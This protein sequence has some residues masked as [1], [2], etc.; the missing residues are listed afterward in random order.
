[1]PITI[2][3][4]KKI[5]RGGAENNDPQQKELLA[6]AAGLLPGPVSYTHLTLPTKA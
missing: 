5:Y 4:K 6:K 3:P 2:G 1:M